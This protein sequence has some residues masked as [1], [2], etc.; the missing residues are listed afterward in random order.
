MISN[1]GILLLKLQE[2][3][4]RIYFFK[5]CDRCFLQ[6]DIRKGECYHC[7]ELDEKGLSDMFKD[8][9]VKFRG[10]RFLGQMFIYVSIFMLILFVLS[11]Y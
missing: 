9:E 4:E 1:I 2:I 10:R 11:F 6:Y 7:S 3:R 5:R 8:R